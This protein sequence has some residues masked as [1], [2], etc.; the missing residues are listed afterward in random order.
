LNGKKEI[1]M[2]NLHPTRDFTFV[3]DTARGF[4]EIARA[5][6]LN[7]EVTNIGM[8]EEIT[9]GDLVRLIASLLNAEIKIIEEKDRIRPDNSEVERLYCDNRKIKEYT[10]WQPQYDLNKGLKETIEWL[11][12][13]LNIY[14]TEIYNV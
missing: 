9:I 1:S 8:S 4:L 7:G 13:N 3:K 6:K 11:K 14:K 5:E 10:S 12:K 2:G